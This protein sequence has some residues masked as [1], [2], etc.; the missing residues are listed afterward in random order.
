MKTEIRTGKNWEISHGEKQDVIP[1]TRFKN[2]TLRVHVQV[3]TNAQGVKI[4]A[5]LGIKPEDASGKDVTVSQLKDEEGLDPQEFLI[6][7]QE[8]AWIA[9]FEEGSDDY[10][11]V[12][13]QK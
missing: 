1:K 3:E 10:L 11:K 13:Q 7:S 8:G 9:F 6:L 2:Q 12:T 5:P 4:P